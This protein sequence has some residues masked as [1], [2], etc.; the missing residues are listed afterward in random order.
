VET[1]LQRAINRMLRYHRKASRP[2][3]VVNGKYVG[4]CARGPLPSFRCFLVDDLAVQ[5][6]KTLKPARGMTQLVVKHSGWMALRPS[7]SKDG[8]A[9][10]EVSEATADRGNPVPD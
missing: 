5:E 8:A 7:Q 3:S 4:M 10:L 1:A 6:H 2:T 9:R